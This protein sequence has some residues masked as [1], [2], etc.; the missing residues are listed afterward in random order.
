MSRSALAIVLAAG[1]GTRMKSSKTKM[2]HDVAG[3]PMAAH[4]VDT[5]S[6]S[7]VDAV[8]LVVGRDGDKVAAAC[9][10]PGVALEAFEQTERLGTAHAV[11]AAREA[12]A[13]GYD[14][15][16]VTYGDTP[17]VTGE[18][19]ARARAALAEGYDV[20]VIGFETAEPAGYGRL[21]TRDGALY[22]IREEKDAS[23][24]ERK[25]TLCNSGLMAFNG[26][27]ALEFLDAIGNDNAKREFYLTDIVEVA[28]SKGGRAGVVMADADEVLGCNNRAELSELERIWQTRRRRALMLDGVTM[29]AP[30]TVFLCHDTVIGA[31]CV[32][33][34]NVVFGPGVEIGESVVIHAFSHIEGARIA[35]GST[36]GPFARLRPGAVLHENAK[37]G[38]FCEVKNG[39][40]GPGAK[41][42]HLS[43][44]G[45][46]TVGARANIG[47][48]TITCNYDGVN[49]F[50]TEIGADSFVGSNS[51]LVA[52]VSIG[53]QAYVGSGSV[54][55]RDVPDNALA[56]ARGRQEIKEGRAEL[57][58]A[59]SLAIKAARKGSK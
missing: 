59:R 45:D 34:P 56:I 52:P 15:V 43:Y 12:L 10:L 7:G 5:V 26:R 25:V 57:L 36:V 9:A 29:I 54:I 24:E 53:A 13:R 39:D 49:K 35:A 55:T 37:V 33:E 19:L 4:V 44:I 48:G 1:D 3:R 46:A 41:I 22:A 51:S 16:I 58:R 6:R 8:A 31:D 50:R 23:A 21:L 27:R 38:N 42:N 20:V 40:I 28:L 11:L 18:T 47:A 14:D 32:I 17:L 30:E 2:L